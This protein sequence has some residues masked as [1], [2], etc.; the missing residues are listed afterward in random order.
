MVEEE[1]AI[2]DDAGSWL[3]SNGNGKHQGKG[4]HTT[5][6]TAAEYIKRK[7]QAIAAKSSL[8]H[9]N[10]NKNKQQII[11]K[12]QI[13][14]STGN[15]TTHHSTTNSTTTLPFEESINSHSSSSSSIFVNPST[16]EEER[17]RHHVE[18]Q[19]QNAWQSMHLKPMMDH[20]TRMRD[21]DTTV[22]LMEHS[23]ELQELADSY[24]SWDLWNRMNHPSKDSSFLSSWLHQPA[25][26]V[27]VSGGPERVVSIVGGGAG[28]LAIDDLGWLWTVASISIEDSNGNDNSGSRFGSIDDD[29][30][31]GQQ[32]QHGF[33]IKTNNNNNSGMRLNHY[34]SSLL[35]LNK[36]VTSIRPVAPEI[37]DVVESRG[38][39]AQ[40]AVGEDFFACMTT[41][42]SILVWSPATGREKKMWH[43]RG[44][45]EEEEGESGSNGTKSDNKW[46]KFNCVDDK[47]TE[48]EEE[49]AVA[50]PSSS[51]SSSSSSL[52]PD[53]S[54]LEIG[55]WLVAE[56][57]LP[58]DTKA[59]TTDNSGNFK[60]MAAGDASLL[61]TDGTSVWQLD[62]ANAFTREQQQ[63]HTTTPWLTLTTQHIP[64]T[65]E[66]RGKGIKEVVAG[67]AAMAVISAGKRNV[68]FW[69]SVLDTDDVEQLMNTIPDDPFGGPE[70]F[71]LRVGVEANAR[72]HGSWPGMRSVKPTLLP[73]LKNVRAVSFGAKH[74]LAVVD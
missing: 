5:T 60:S 9:N 4:R 57:T 20:S 30:T 42:G 25:M 14:P 47:G 62:I 38:G 48:G 69:G 56:I 29:S 53:V 54:L 41:S 15:I 24:N 16:G 44:D 49:G 1:Y 28:V 10:N 55:D 66:D 74:A 67:G 65:K 58:L 3:Q 27:K 31:K 2:E 21:L 40:V 70:V 61:C 39:A 33:N 34:F 43:D 6:I 68:Y 46:V 71:S 17:L 22:R 26:P 19:V 8:H 72:R 51:S 13:S 32:Y 73:E 36:I 11:T 35:D 59:I 64:L 23:T 45:D 7:K 18:Y 52:V 63:L 12:I 37:A 50:V